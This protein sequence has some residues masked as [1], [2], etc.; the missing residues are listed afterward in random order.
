MADGGSSSLIPVRAHPRASKN[1]HSLEEDGTLHI[2]VT[3][4]AVEGAAN[5]A[6]IR[7]LAEIL[8][9]P[10]TRIAIV[11]GESGRVKRLRVDLPVELVSERLERGPGKK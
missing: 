2:W 5:K 6:V 9:V 10:Q 8:A 1:R 4:P 7:Y 11:S 3:A